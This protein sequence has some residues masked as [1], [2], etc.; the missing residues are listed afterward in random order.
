MYKRGLV[1]SYHNYIL[2]IFIYAPPWYTKRKYHNLE[3]SM[4]AMIKRLRNMYDFREDYES[5]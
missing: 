4:R 1:A 2:W 3:S 5:I